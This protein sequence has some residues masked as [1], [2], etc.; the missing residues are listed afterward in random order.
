M[1]CPAC[2]TP[3]DPDARFCKECGS[4]LALACASCGTPIP[5]GGKFCTACGTPVG[6]PAATPAAGRAA[7]PAPAAASAATSTWAPQDTTPAAERRVVTVLF[8]DLVGFTPLAETRDAEETRELLTRYY[9]LARRLVGRYGGTVEKF[10]GDAVMAVWGTPVAHEDDAERAVRSALDLLEAVAELGRESGT[11]LAA[12]AGVLT[13]EAAV[14]LDAVGQ[15]MVAGDMVN[16]AAR[17]QSVAPPNAVLVGE[18]T[19]VASEGGIAYE[20]AGEQLLKGKA[21]PVAAY[22]A[23]RVIARVGGEGRSDRLEPPFVGRHGELRMLKDLF[24]A[25]GEE[26]RARLVSVIGQAGIGKSRLAWELQ[27]YLDGVTEIAYWHQGRCP[28][29]GEGVSFW[30]L[31]E[32]IRERAKIPEGADSVAAGDRL[33]ATLEEFVPDEAERRWLEPGL[34]E[35]LGLDPGERGSGASA[36][37]LFAAWRTLFERIAAHGTVVLIFEDLHWADPGLLDFIEH[38]LEWSRSHPIF[39]V[40][41]ARPEL[42][43]RRPNWGAGWRNLTSLG[44][45]PLP[46]TAMR[47]LLDGLVPGLPRAAA[48]RILARAEG[49]PLYAVETVRMLIADGRL[50]PADGAY[51]PTGDLSDMAVPETLQALVASRLDGLPPALR[52]LVHDGSV[53][54]KTFSLDALADVSARSRTELAGPLRDLVRREL[55]VLDADPRSPERGQY[56]FVQ[57]VI[58]EVAYGMISRR[59]RRRLHLAAARHFE[60]LGDDELAGVLAGHYLDAWRARPEGPEGAAV[61]TQARLAL[62]AAADRAIRL[63]S[64]DLAL[65]YLEQALDVAK[66]DADRAELHL[67]A[68]QTGFEAAQLPAAERH[69]NRAAELSAAHGARP[70]ELV[71][72]AWLGLARMAAG[73][74][75]Q[76]LGLLE[77]AAERFADLEGSAEHVAL[78]EALARCYMRMGRLEQGVALCDRALGPAARHQLTRLVLELLVTRATI[79]GGQGRLTES[80]ATMTGAVELAAEHGYIALQARGLTNLSFVLGPDDP[81]RAFDVSRRGADLSY[82]M[83]RPLFLSGLLGNAVEFGFQVGEWDVLDSLLQPALELNLDPVF[84]GQLLA[85][86]AILHAYRCEPYHHELEG[87]L[88]VASRDDPQAR[89]SIDAIWAQIG[90]A[91]G[92]FDEVDERA[93]SSLREFAPAVTPSSQMQAGRAALWSG[94]LD[95]AQRAADALVDLPGRVTAAHRMELAAGIAALEGREDEAVE[96]S[97]EAT[98][99]YGELGLAFER[100]LCQTSAAATLGPHRREI[101]AAADDA[102]RMLT[103]L[104]AAPFLERLDE[105]LARQAPRDGVGGAAAR[106]ASREVV[107]G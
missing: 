83:G 102:R 56:G 81:A 24:H 98:R 62:R 64:Y 49:V 30:A 61:A 88:A 42:F 21:A 27:K 29:Y 17:L 40:T 41:L 39:V 19:R 72:T 7:E 5:P 63:A 1:D 54:G 87:A 94:N 48:D 6:T 100:S 25:V 15:G 59:E 92:R 99:A 46:E 96:R 90:L 47:E 14:N 51:R 11:D 67:L 103:G 34:R 76:T 71:A 28:A 50:E 2:R 105:A 31:S 45:E 20:P 55:L 73:D 69:L 26:R 44:L 43:D 36:E 86:L 97:A 68:G 91:E 12:R 16:T 58:R 95:R 33:A 10:V 9:D 60:S 23:L 57:S 84:Q 82:R 70:E 52:T 77:Q 22:R 38:L 101:Q 8:A 3:N 53:L 78:A 107:S 66:D 13:G 74:I 18:R 32:M 75:E 106:R 37:T 80:V 65:R 35:L 93:W 85:S 89:A 4:A 104:R 79:L